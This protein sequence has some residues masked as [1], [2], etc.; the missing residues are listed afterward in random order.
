MIW[1]ELIL[2]EGKSYEDMIVAQTKY[3]LKRFGRPEDVAYL[4][5]YMLSD[6]SLWMTGSCVEITGGENNIQTLV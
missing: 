5:V 6:A 4:A 2:R 1:S 3:P